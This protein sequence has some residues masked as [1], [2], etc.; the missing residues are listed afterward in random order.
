VLRVEEEEDDRRR[1]VVGILIRR[2]TKLR[3]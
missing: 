1:S 2:K 3:K